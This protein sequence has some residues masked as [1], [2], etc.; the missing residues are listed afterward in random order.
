MV[1]TS[2]ALNCKWTR[3]TKKELHILLRFDFLIKTKGTIYTKLLGH[4][5]FLVETSPPIMYPRKKALVTGQANMENT[6][7]VHNTNCS[8]HKGVVN[9]LIRP[10]FW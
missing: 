2:F 1:S 10:W 5:T 6:D 4:K 8:A 9:I 7:S 3:K